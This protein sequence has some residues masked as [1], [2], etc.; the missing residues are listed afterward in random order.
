MSLSNKEKDASVNGN[1]IN[2]DQ[3]NTKYLLQL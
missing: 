2:L 3:P 1:D